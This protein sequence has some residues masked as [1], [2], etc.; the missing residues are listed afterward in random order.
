MFLT[1]VISATLGFIASLAVVPM[2]AS[3][4]RKRKLLDIPNERSS[5]QVPTPKAGGGGILFG[6]F[7]GCAAGVLLGGGWPEVSVLAMLGIFLFG[8]AVGF[9]DDVFDL[10]T[11]LRMGLY[12]ACATGSA[13][14]GA[15]VTSIA[16]PGLPVVSIGF[17][18]GLVSS[19]LFIAWYTNLF[20]FMDG[21]DGIA[22]GAAVVVLGALCA[23]FFR[24]GETTW[25]LIALVSA[26]ACLGF[27]VHNYP[28][29]TVFMGDGG[30]V[31][32]GL[33]A[34]ALS[35]VAVGKGLIA[36]PAVMLLMLPF[37]FDATFT[38]IR[39]MMRRER[40][41][42]AHRS[43]V[44][45]QMCDLGL[46]HRAITII[47]TA[48]AAGFAALGLAYGSLPAWGKAL[49]WWGALT[50]SLIACLFVVFKNPRQVSP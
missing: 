26:A 9:L 30:A 43:H 16:L 5:H 47:Y 27:L 50:A 49:T 25:A 3:V 34:G 24:G 23:V 21:I 15:H 42:A 37:V 22:G 46:T 19:C 28:P 1:A 10:P 41:W 4:A 40:F 17:G 45:Q 20:N 48:A 29:A 38:L 35:L 31:F 39:R 33:E 8:S 11:G 12:L 2:A 44:Y 13:L 7:T 18:G 14:A 32:L 6:A 36:V